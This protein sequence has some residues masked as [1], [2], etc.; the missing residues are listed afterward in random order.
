MR[1]SAREKK[2]WTHKPTGYIQFLWW[3]DRSRGNAK[4]TNQP[5]IFRGWTSTSA[6]YFLDRTPAKNGFHSK[7]RTG[8]NHAHTAHAQETGWMVSRKPIC[9]QAQQSQ[10]IVARLSDALPH[11]CN[12]R[13]VDG[14]TASRGLGDRLRACVP[15]R[16]CSGIC[17]CRRCYGYIVNL[18]RMFPDLFAV[19]QDIF[20]HGHDKFASRYKCHKA[21]SS[22][23]WGRISLHHVNSF[24]V[25]ADV[26]VMD[27]RHIY[28]TLS[29]MRRSLRSPEVPELPAS[30]EDDRKWGEHLRRHSSHIIQTKDPL[31][32][33]SRVIYANYLLSPLNFHEVPSWTTNI[34]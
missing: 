19:F 21:N 20:S 14:I 3:I 31:I 4:T 33:T 16:M 9:V 17:H 26:Q 24:E 8:S 29:Q 6:C 7:G 10:Q 32:V 22:S 27:S 13:S 18:F 30:S 5:W 23:H 34:T 15:H 12:H 1:K 2:C 11:L 25:V 28:T